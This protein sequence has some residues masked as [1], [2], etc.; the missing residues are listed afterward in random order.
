PVHDRADRRL[1]RAL[2]SRSLDAPEVLAAGGAGVEPRIERGADTT[3]MEVA[4]RAR[5]EPGANFHEFADPSVDE[6]TGYCR[7]SAP[8]RRPPDG[9]AR[10]AHG[11]RAARKLL[12]QARVLL[13]TGV[14]LPS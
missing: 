12:T 2:P 4:G 13:E 8:S 7:G 3:D 1:G 6:W 9:L 5:G 11:T 10:A 14:P